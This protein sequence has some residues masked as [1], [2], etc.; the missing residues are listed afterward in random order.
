MPLE[1]FMKSCSVDQPPRSLTRHLTIQRLREQVIQFILFA[2]AL[3]SIVTTVGIIYIL[4]AESIVGV[5][6]NT[7]YFEEVSPWEFFTG[8]EWT[9]QFTDP[10]YG[11]LP[12]LSGTLLIAGIAAMI[13]LPIGLASAIYLSEFASTRTRNFIKPILEIL[14][15]IPTVVY[16]YF[17]LV[18]VT[19][20]VL[21]PI[22]QDLLGFEVDIFNAASAGIVVGIMI[23]PMVSSLSEDTL[24]AIPRSLREAGYAL[25][26][27]K[28]D[29]STKIVLPAAIS[30]ILS[31][32]LLAISRA[33]GETMAVTIAAGQAPN[34]T[35]NPFRSVQT[36]TSYIV[37][38]SLG[39]T[40][41]GS[42]S[43]KSLYAIALTLF[44]MTLTMNFLSHLI[45]RRFR[46][47]YE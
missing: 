12:L 34:L 7:A 47:V 1:T 38:V 30:G 15:G 32:F 21:R 2:C 33:V 25:G 16:G 35:M 22:F 18:F 17:A 9:P 23:I 36:M 20:Y 31:S 4:V 42:M 43:Y 14:A 29:V 26:S 27:T 8:T 11:V 46:E 45:M 3:L 40:P 5:G 19:P 37:N 24:R 6:G 10:Q 13:G 41:V 28:F 39:D 44:C